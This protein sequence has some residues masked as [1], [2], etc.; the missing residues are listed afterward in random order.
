[1]S[2]C[3]GCQNRGLETLEE[4]N[5]WGGQNKCRGVINVLKSKIILLLLERMV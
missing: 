4:F 1:M 3:K 5:K 2:N